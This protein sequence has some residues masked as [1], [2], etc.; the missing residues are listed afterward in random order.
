MRAFWVVC[1]AWQSVIPLLQTLAKGV[2][3]AITAAMEDVSPMVRQAV[4]ND[5]IMVAAG[6]MVSTTV[7][8]HINRNPP[9][10]GGGI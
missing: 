5:G 4:I 3:R 9:A 1:Y 8:V 7:V 6:F 10:R 2:E